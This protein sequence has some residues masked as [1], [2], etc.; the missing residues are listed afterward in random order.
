MRTD[1][2][3]VALIAIQTALLR[4]YE[5]LPLSVRGRIAHDALANAA[6]WVADHAALDAAPTAETGEA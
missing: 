6:T 2:D 5:K 4:R 1:E 3:N